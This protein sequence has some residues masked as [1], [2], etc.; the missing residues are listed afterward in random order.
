MNQ[1]AC[2]RA[3]IAFGNGSRRNYPADLTRTFATRLRA[4]G[5]HDDIS[6]LFSDSRA[7]VTRVYARATRTV[8][9][10]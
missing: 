9:E 7:G 4:N 6:D 5:V 10:G 8:L 3:E 1:E 2:T